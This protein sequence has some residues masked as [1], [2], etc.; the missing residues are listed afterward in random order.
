MTFFPI[1]SWKSPTPNSAMRLAQRATGLLKG[2]RPKQSGRRRANGSEEDEAKPV[3]VYRRVEELKKKERSRYP[4]RAADT[5]V[6]TA[7]GKRRRSMG[8]PAIAIHEDVNDQDLQTRRVRKMSAQE[9][10]HQEQDEQDG[11][12]SDETD[13]EDEP[14]ESVMEDMK[15]LEESFEGISQKYRL[16]NRIGEGQHIQRGIGNPSNMPQ[17]PFRPYTKRSSCFTS[18]TSMTRTSQT[19]TLLKTPLHQN[20]ANLQPLPRLHSADPD[21]VPNSW[22]SR[23]YMSLH[24]QTVYSTS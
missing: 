23:R 9:S 16:I 13:S 7:T 11:D 8:H 18:T 17:V 21:P 10:L 3:K 5:V 1:G 22:L 4:R 2:L 6:A 24:H 14:D 19:A 20:D 15:K 12:M